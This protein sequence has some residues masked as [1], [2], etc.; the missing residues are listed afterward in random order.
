LD[1]S[2][3]RAY[4]DV[5]EFVQPGGSRKPR[6]DTEA[7][8]PAAIKSSLPKPERLATLFAALRD[9]ADRGDYLAA[10]QTA[11]TLLLEDPQLESFDPRE[12]EVLMRVFEAHLGRMDQVPLVSVPMHE[13][14]A[15]NLDHRTG[16]LLSRID[17]MLTYEDILDVAGM[18]RFEAY[19]ILSSLLR[20]GFIEV[21]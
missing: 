4:D 3:L 7:E 10:V 21:R 18:P 16:F 13:I 9:D 14:S 20:R 6:P 2:V 11:E 19:R 15:A 8:T 12:K 5:V 1:E 17:G